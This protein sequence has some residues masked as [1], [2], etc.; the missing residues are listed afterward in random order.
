MDNVFCVFVIVD[1]RG[2]WGFSCKFVREPV[3]SDWSFCSHD[4]FV[5]NRVCFIVVLLR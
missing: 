2:A 1:D 3:A 5:A 4:F